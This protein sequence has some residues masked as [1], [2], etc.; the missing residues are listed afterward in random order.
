MTDVKTIDRAALAAELDRIIASLDA[1]IEGSYVFTTHA[2]I[3]DDVQVFASVREQEAVTSVIPV[4][5]AERLGLPI[6]PSYTRISIGAK[7]SLD[8]VGITA[9]VAQTLAS[10]EIPCNV[11]A[12]FW[13][14]HL[15]VPENQAGEAQALLNALSEQ[16][17]GWSKLPKS[18]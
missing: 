7:T 15:F 8:T 2:P 9:M 3:P 16:A 6:E 12:G 1:R 14:D 18:D 5:E 10:R 17:R 13:H 4:A 11:I